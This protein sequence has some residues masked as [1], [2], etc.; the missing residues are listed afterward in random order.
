[1]NPGYEV[2]SDPLDMYMGRCIKYWLDQ[3]PPPASG[4]AKLLLSASS[5]PMAQQVNKP[6]LGL[7]ALVLRRGL[8]GLSY[9]MAGPH[10]LE[11][12][13]SKMAMVFVTP[14]SLS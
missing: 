12:M 13:P 7:V 11:T 6:F 2:E 1:M 10:E 14:M 9:L 4:R 8:R 5:M 3:Y